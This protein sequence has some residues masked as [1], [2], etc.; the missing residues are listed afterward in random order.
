[1]YPRDR[2]EV[3]VKI[4]N[5]KCLRKVLKYTFRVL[6]RCMVFDYLTDKKIF[7]NDFVMSEEVV[8]S[9][10]EAGGEETIEH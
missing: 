10:C 8:P 4:D 9:K 1:M 6:R 7:Q 3:S 2:A 5:T